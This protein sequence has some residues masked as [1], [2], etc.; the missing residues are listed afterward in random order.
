MVKLLEYL[1]FGS[2][3]IHSWVIVAC[4]YCNSLACHRYSGAW[5]RVLGSA[6]V[7]SGG[8]VPDSYA[9]SI[10]TFSTGDIETVTAP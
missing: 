9:E 7:L 3:K 1:C 10:L 2:F 8:S 5:V 4:V 6:E